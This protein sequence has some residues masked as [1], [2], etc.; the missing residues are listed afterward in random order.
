MT[1]YD[2]L[3][4]QVADLYRAGELHFGHG[5]QTA[6]DEAWW[7]VCAACQIEPD[8]ELWNG[9]ATTTQAAQQ[10]ALSLARRRIETRQPLAYLLNE[11]WFAGERYYVDERVLVPRSHLGDWIPEQ[12]SPWIKPDQVE[13]ILDIGTGSGCIAIA[14][15]KAFPGAKLVATDLSA[16]ALEVAKLNAERHEVS[17]RIEFMQVDIYDGSRRAFDLIVSNPPYV[18]DAAMK[19]LP[20]EYQPE[21]QMAFR[22]G[23]DG[24]QYIHR[25]I[26]GARDGWLSSDGMLIM[27]IATAREA[28]DS[29]YP[30]NTL[31]WLATSAEEDALMLASREELDALLRHNSN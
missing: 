15:A 30:D 9:E 3:V 20:K 27:E 4:E 29:A 19:V 12:F 5:T 22:G 13:R 7:T 23:S 18:S 14:L 17:D 26:A 21:P 16:P 31:M 10:A 6:L 8:P 24:L 2:A 25:I 28:F 11:A 1:N